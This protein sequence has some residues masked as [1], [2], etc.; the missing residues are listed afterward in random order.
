MPPRFEARLR[1]GVPEKWLWIGAMLA[2]SLLICLPL[3]KSDIY[4]ESHEQMR[5]PMRTLGIH[6]GLE[7]GQMPPQ[8]FPNLLG[9]LGYGWH[10][11]YPPLSY[12][13]IEF[14]YGIGLPLLGAVKVSDVLALFL[15][16]VTMFLFVRRLFSND[17]VAGIAG[18][19]YLSAPY[20][21]IDFYI[22][23]AHAETFA[24]IWVPVMF[25]GAHEIFQ[26][27]TEKWWILAVGTSGVL[28]THIISGFY[29]LFFL[30]FFVILR[31]VFPLKEQSV[32]YKSIALACAKAAALTL[33][34][35]AFF[36]LPMFEHRV[37]GNYAIFSKAYES[38]Y[39][40][41]LSKVQAL[42]LT[43][44]QMFDWRII[45]F[46]G[47]LGSI[48]YRHQGPQMPLTVGATL[49]ILAA[50]GLVRKRVD[51][52][53][54]IFVGLAVLSLF[55]TSWLMP[56]TKLP[57][58]FSV[59]QFPWR[60]LLFGTFF[61]CILA[62]YAFRNSQGRFV[63]GAA[64][65]VACVLL[66]DTVHQVVTKKVEAESLTMNEP[67]SGMGTSGGEYCPVAFLEAEAKAKA[68]PEWI[69]QTLA[70]VLLNGSGH[71][72]VTRRHGVN[73]DL[74]VEIE[75]AAQ[76]FVTLQIPLIYY[77]GY[78]ITNASGEELKRY[79]CKNGLLCVDIKKSGSYEVRYGNT[80]IGQIG[81]GLSLV[82]LFVLVAVVGVWFR[83]RS[84]ADSS[85]ASG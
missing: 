82:A 49:G 55:M 38:R 37:T 56:W 26:G 16:G 48:G 22:R 71:V 19:L 17:R 13:F 42:G 57:A 14:F 61:L 62:S 32:D 15:S 3:L 54:F 52:M 60:L 2:L 79:E 67:I 33:A 35:T 4:F 21:L 84:L 25:L 63:K 58:F 39:G 46:Y 23:N 81:N 44:A 43:L 47:P 34:L 7:G 40:M 59:L 74:N 36:F 9:G 53:Q 68:Q 78:R 27:N 50:L 73:F 5:A 41:L 85:A 75:N 45:I 64:V 28:L 70:P 30:T 20:H 1:N 76:G 77:L 24:F 10:L 80:R 29:S 11:F 65:L 6:Q 8:V 18:L 31:L 69:K 66:V 83:N 51:R 12:W 72:T